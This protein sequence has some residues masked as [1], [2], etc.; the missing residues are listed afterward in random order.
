MAGQQAATRS[1]A[2]AH[3]QHQSKLLLV[4]RET[5]MDL[6]E[7]WLD[8]LRLSAHTNNAKEAHGQLNSIIDFYNR[9]SKN[10]GLTVSTVHLIWNKGI[11][12]EDWEKEI[13]TPEV[14]GKIK[15]MYSKFMTAEYDVDNAV[16]KIG[17]KSEEMRQIEVAATYNFYLW[18]A[19]YMPHVE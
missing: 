7:K 18:L 15:K 14:V 16:S 11:D 4:W 3:Y 2:V 17:N 9:K 12:W 19:H 13:Q 8:K 6:N 5:G 1:A 10:T